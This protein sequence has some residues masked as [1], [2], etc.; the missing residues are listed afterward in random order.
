MVEDLEFQFGEEAMQSQS[1]GNQGGD[2]PP[3]VEFGDQDFSWHP[4]EGY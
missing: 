1:D 2:A 3:L 4:N